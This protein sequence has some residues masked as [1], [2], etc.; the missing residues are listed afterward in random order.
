MFGKKPKEKRPKREYGVDPYAFKDL[1][2]QAFDVLENDLRAIQQTLPREDALRKQIRIVHELRSLQSYMDC[3]L[4]RESGENEPYIPAYYADE[5]E[6]VTNIA[7]DHKWYV[8]K[9]KA[10]ALD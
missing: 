4:E 10:P 3:T 6:N 5:L 8:E 2:F 1:I 7:V 9:E